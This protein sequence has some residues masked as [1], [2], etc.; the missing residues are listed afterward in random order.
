MKISNLAKIRVFVFY[1]KIYKKEQ[2]FVVRLTAKR[3]YGLGETPMMLA[4]N[5][6]ISDLRNKSIILRILE[7]EI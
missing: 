5:K 3:V 2:D 4:T 6:N 7:L 1:P